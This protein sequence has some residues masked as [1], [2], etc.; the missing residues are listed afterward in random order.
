MKIK[1]LMME[2]N[3]YAPDAEIVLYKEDQNEIDDN[4][5]IGEDENPDSKLTQPMVFIF[6][7]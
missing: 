3:E 5:C 1:E 7:S 6:V 4:I 2:L